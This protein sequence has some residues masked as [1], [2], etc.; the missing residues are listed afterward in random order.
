M[1]P[2]LEVAGLTLTLAGPS[3]P[4]PLV[5]DVGFTIGRGEKFG[6]VGESGSGKSLLALSLIRLLPRGISAA[7]TVRFDGRDLLALPEPAMHAL[8]G[9][10][11]G[12]IFQEPVAALNPVF[13]I[14]AQITAAIR[15]HAPMPRRRARERAVELLSMVGIPDAGGRLGFFPHQLSG[16]LC[17][18]VMIAMAIAGG[19]R[20]LIADE[21]TTSLDVTIQEEIVELIAGL[22]RDAGIAVLFIS[23]DLGVVARLCDRI[24]VVY[25]GQMQEIGPAEAL[26]R[27]P[28]HPYTAGL[29]RC[30]PDL[31][32][33]GAAHRGIPGAPPLP[34]TW[35]IGCRFA[36]RCELATDACAAPQTLDAIAADRMVRCWRAHDGARAATD[37]RR[38]AGPAG[39]H[40]DDRALIEVR[41]LDVTYR[42][43]FGRD[44]A[45]VA[46]V[47][48][49]ITQG[50]TLALIGESGSGKS[51]VARAICGLG[52]VSGGTIAL[53]GTTI[54]GKQAAQLA[55]S[56][57]IQVVSQDPT[58]SL[59][60]RWP[61]WRSINEPRLVRFPRDTDGGRGRAA[62]LLEHVGL[63][64]SMLDRRPH[65][66]SGGQR[67]R[68][69]IARALAPGPRVIIL[70]E[71]VSALDVSVRNEILVLLGELQRE[72]GISYLLISHDIGAVT[73]IA[74][75]V[76]V[77][78]RGRLAELGR[79]G[80]VLG[81][82]LHPYTRMLIRAV[83]TIDDAA[84]AREPAPALADAA[85]PPAA[86]CPFQ[87][88]CAHAEARCAAERPTLRLLHGRRVACHLAEALA[89][90]NAA[91]QMA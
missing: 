15:A 69:T 8:R 38:A 20:L 36:A 61:I 49:D 57:G 19:A 26:L 76:A 67:Q 90:E 82:P 1:A 77:L 50:R 68:V 43:G 53:D 84:L 37:H 41:D 83:P 60:P 87:P 48:F 33:I 14:G 63:D 54:A 66:L 55:G 78:Y 27:A 2:L 47:S 85:P 71:A 70:D 30:V 13:S 73:Q 46:G 59:D 91:A 64:R 22:A 40:A 45:A 86:G 58:A 56:L 28:A 80:D 10:Q 39:R 9:A 32:D 65:Q 23:H 81:A 89:A 16:G 29:V 7:G 31:A 18:R 74:A 6:L 17:Q 88:R 34:G 3:G 12:M 25:A 5:S 44:V 11:I 62:E 24:A 42:V 79:A 72:S 51:T 35:P 21:P 52:P 4:T 75:E